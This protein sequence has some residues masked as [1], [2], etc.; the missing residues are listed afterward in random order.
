MRVMWQGGVFKFSTNTFREMNIVDDVHRLRVWIGRSEGMV[1]QRASVYEMALAMVP[2]VLPQGLHW[3]TIR[4]ID[5]I[6]HCR[7]VLRIID[8]A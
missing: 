3:L 2:E 8:D 6:E 4:V 5:T 1:Y 7:L